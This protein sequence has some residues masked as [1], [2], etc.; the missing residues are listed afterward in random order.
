MPPSA[1]SL[2]PAARQRLRRSF[3]AAYANAGL[4]GVGSGLASVTLIIFLVRIRGASG[5]EISW[6]LAAP[7]LAG[8]VRLAAPAWI[9]CLGSRRRF[10]VAAFGA[11]AAVLAAMPLLASPAMIPSPR[12]ARAGIIATWVGYH[13]LEAL[14]VVALWAWLADIIPAPIRG[15]VLGRREAWLNIGAVVGGAAAIAATMLWPRHGEWWLGQSMAEATLEF[16]AYAACGMAGATAMAAAA[17][18]LLGI[19]DLPRGP[20]AAPRASRG[21]TLSN[22]WGPLR[23]EG[24]RRF[25]AFG[26]WFSFSNGVIQTPQ[27]IYPIGPLGFSF[28]AKKTLDGASRALKAALLPWVGR[29]V[30]RRG[31]VRTLAVSQA[32]IATA[33]LFLLWATPIN[34]WWIL[35]AYACWLAYA[36]HDVTLNN[37]MLSFSPPGQAARYSAAWL[38]WTQFAFAISVLAGGMLFDLLEASS[39]SLA[40]AGRPL[41]HF[42]ILFTAGWLLKAL[43]VPL[44]TRIR[45]P[46]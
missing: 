1:I 41:N 10:C 37:L 17:I 42:A 43:G 23:D 14:G 19:V 16:Q 21:L 34:P 40:L 45:P 13:V 6:I 36:G 20:W 29:R 8:L 33:P 22:L 35:G 2:A 7:S 38:A 3:A 12:A 15:R 28:A 18:G 30:D 39:M 31:S 26:L 46:H 24:F 9:D 11:S 32:I 27:S 25:M 4:W 44:A 5:A